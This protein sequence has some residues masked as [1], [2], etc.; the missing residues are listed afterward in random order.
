MRIFVS[1]PQDYADA[2]KPG[3]TAT[4]T[5]PQNPGNAIPA[6]FLTPANAVNTPTRTIVTEF[7][8]DNAQGELWPGTYANVH[9]NLPSDPNILI[10][11]QQALL[12]RAQGMQVAVLDGQDRVHLQDVVLGRNLNTDV[13]IVSGL[14]ATDKVVG[15]PSLG[16]LD[17]QQVRIV[18]PVQGYQPDSSS[19]PSG[20]P[21]R[22]Q[23]LTTTEPSATA[24]SPVPSATQAAP[25][26]GSKP[27]AANR[28]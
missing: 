3:L 12:F 27:A 8:V 21:Q 1:V 24:A 14:K 6:Q 10:L 22:G 5:L 17:G 15:N 28:H 26:N 16:L 13:Q 18:Q 23:P 19:K 9:F 7:T 2:L 4:L 25:L 20:P 11:P